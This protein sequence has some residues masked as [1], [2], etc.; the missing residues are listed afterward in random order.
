MVR[1]VPGATRRYPGGNLDC[2]RD[3]AGEAAAGLYLSPHDVRGLPRLGRHRPVRLQYGADLVGRSSRPPS[4]QTLALYLHESKPVKRFFESSLPPALHPTVEEAFRLATRVIFTAHATSEIFTELNANDNFRLLPGWV[5][6]ARIEQFAAAHDP[7]DL[8]RKHGLDPA[9]VIVVNI[10]TV[11][12]RKGQHVFIR[13]IELL[14]KE[15]PAVFPGK[16]SMGHRRRPP[17][18]PWRR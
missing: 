12:E 14:Q 5:D 4:R 13:G 9:A 10:G 7:A 6:F 17:R 8:R 18:L 1:C 2:R 3:L 16:K 11:C 15:R